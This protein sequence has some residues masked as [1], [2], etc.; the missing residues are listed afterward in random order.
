ML[1][2]FLVAMALLLPF[3]PSAR[4]M[5]QNASGH[6]VLQKEEE[7]DIVKELEYKIKT[8]K[9]FL[10]AATQIV[11]PTKNK[12]AVS[13]LKMAE[14][15]AKEGMVHY[16]TGELKLA[17]E[18]LSESTQ[19]AIHSII[20]AK[21]QQD[22]SIRDF[23]IQ[24][25]MLL[26]E[27]RDRERKESMINK[28]TEEVEAFIRTADKLL[29]ANPD[30][31]ASRNI[32][33]VK[34]LLESSRTGLNQEKYDNS[35]AEINTAYKLVTK[36]V[37]DIKRSQDDIITFPKPDLTDEKDVLAYE[38]KR[39][40][41]YIFFADQ[42]VKQDDREADKLLRAGKDTKDEAVK[43]LEAGDTPKAIEKYRLSTEF[44][45]KAVKISF[46]EKEAPSPPQK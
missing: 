28:R 4:V 18:D 29:A 22:A 45:I 33:E 43:A 16:K 40:N 35:L 9:A 11:E 32:K 36:T 8:Q 15:L 12:D 14:S 23:V 7:K 19:M 10:K 30:E 39:N 44:L 24:E 26:N 20:L 37:K 31:A 46:K 5:A 3:V 27:R 2:S 13:Y 42:V 17:L 38:V 1:K 25:E 21:N 41:A 34:E 6:E